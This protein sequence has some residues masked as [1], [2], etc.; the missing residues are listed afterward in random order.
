MKSIKPRKLTNARNREHLF[1]HSEVL[2][3]ISEELAERFGF[4]AERTAYTQL[5]SIAEKAAER[6]RGFYATTAVRKADKERDGLATYARQIARA[7]LNS[8]SEAMR[9]AAKVVIYVMEPFK[10]SNTQ[11]DDANS[12]DVGKLVERLQAEPVAGCVATLGLTETVRLL[13][14]AND[15]FVKLQEQRMAEYYERLQTPLPRVIRPQLDRALRK[16]V[17]TLNAMYVANALVG[18]DPEVEAL[19]SG[20]IDN[21]NAAWLR[22]AKNVSTRAARAAGKRE[23]EEE[24]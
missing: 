23:K 7:N 1:F 12:G 11:N 21:V 3:T 19:L 17:K 9:E 4:A 15:R 2:A 8:P 6:R 20:V 10:K 5:F 16:C 18:K 24:A 13:G 22:L 14:E